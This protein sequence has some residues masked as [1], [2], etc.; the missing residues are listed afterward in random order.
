MGRARGIASAAARRHAYTS[1]RGE[2]S[3]DSLLLCALGDGRDADVLTALH[4]H[5]PGVADVLKGIASALG[6]TI[7]FERARSLAN[8]Q[9]DEAFRRAYRWTRDYTSAWLRHEL[10]RARAGERPPV[11]LDELVDTADRELREVVRR[12]RQDP[13]SAP[14]PRRV[15]TR[16]RRPVTSRPADGS[17]SDGAPAEAGA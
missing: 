4:E 14:R 2:L 10:K 1:R 12:W 7:T 15:V 9:R 8:S 3:Y 5:G 17:P 13:A 11:A 16:S 6:E